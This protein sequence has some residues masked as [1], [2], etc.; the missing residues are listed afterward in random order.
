MTDT[1]TILGINGRNG[2]EVAKA[3]VSAGWHVIGM[4]RTNRAKLAG[5]EFVEGDANNVDDIKRATARAGV[6]FNALNLP[7]DKWDKGRAEALLSRVLTALK[8]SGKTM[9]FPGNIYNYSAKQHLITPD[10]P[11]QPE[12]DKGRIRVRMEEMLARATTEDN[13]QV[14][15]I[16]SADF[17]APHAVETNFDLAML[18]RLKSKI[19][20]YPGKLEVGHS[21]AYLP[22]LGRAYVKIAEARAELPRF[23]NFQF[24]GHYATGHEMIAA[25]Q[26]VL[27]QR[28]KVKLVPW[29]LLRIIG[30]F[31]PVLRAVVEMNYL[32]AEPHRLEDKKLE[33][34]LGPNFETPFEQA[35]ASTVRSYL[36]ASEIKMIQKAAA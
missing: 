31:V 11:Q 28:L 35:V 30:T 20:Q 14:I 18:A 13:L 25:I 10:T 23:E 3:F 1:I 29:W 32:W 8:G 4:G 5:V 9:L 17:Y 19:L 34:L 2:Q 22:D 16:R 24:R 33:A 21:W 12:K 7:Y 36:P 26:A 15:I 27:P 6:V